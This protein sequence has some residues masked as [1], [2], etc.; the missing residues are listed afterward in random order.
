[1]T[2]WERTTKEDGQTRKDICLY[3]VLGKHEK[4]IIRVQA[5][6][7]G[8]VSYKNDWDCRNI[9]VGFSLCSLK[10]YITAELRRC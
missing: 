1:M 2:A 4:P 8:K 10:R 7:S 6:A 3:S 9:R 5:E